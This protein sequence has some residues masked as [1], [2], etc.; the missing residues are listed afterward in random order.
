M[1]EARLSG[2]TWEVRA[3]PHV[4]TRLKRIFPRA[5]GYARGG[6]TLK[7]TDEVCRDLLWVAERWPLEILPR[8]HAEARASRHVE[9]ERLFAAIVSGA[10]APRTFETAL[11]LRDYQRV[12]AELALRSG[13]LLI[14]DDLGVGKTAS[15]IGALVDGAARPA[16][17]VTMTHLVTQWTRELARFAP[18][19][20]VHALKTGK[21]YPPPP[22]SR[23]SRS[24]RTGCASSPRRFS[25]S[26]ASRHT[27]QRF[28]RRQHEALRCT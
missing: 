25:R 28:W 20:R 11:P 12:A 14:A 6:V 19:L 16:L 8:S 1:G 24:T 3:E 21:P 17:V 26:A 10:T 5:Y 9:T 27:C 18:Q 15:A 22:S 7:D 13:G 2:A 4:I 23:S